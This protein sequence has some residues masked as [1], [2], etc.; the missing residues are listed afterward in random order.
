VD[1]QFTG[2]GV[3]LQLAV[4]EQQIDTLQAQL[5]GLS[6]GRILLQR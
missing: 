3:H 1:E 2:N 5:A 6:R 4:A